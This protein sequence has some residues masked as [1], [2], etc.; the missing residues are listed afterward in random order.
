MK[1]TNESI[2]QAAVLLYERVAQTQPPQVSIEL[3]TYAWNRIQD[4]HRRIDTARTRGWHHA[5]K[6]LNID[7]ATAVEDCRRR[8]LETHDCLQEINGTP[9]Y[10]VS[11][12][13]IHRDLTA[14]ESEFTAL[15]IDLKAHELAVTTDEITLEDV[16][17]GKFE[18]R[19]N[20]DDLGKLRKPYR[21][22][23][24]DPHPAAK[25]NDVTHP[26]VQDE[27]LCEGEGKPAIA[28][29]LSAGR[30]YDFFMLVS[31][32]LHTYGRGAAFVELDEW[33]CVPCDDCGSNVDSDDR[34]LCHRCDATLCGECSCTCPGCDE[35][36][37]SGCLDK[38]CVCEEEF[39]WSCL[40]TCPECK[41]QCCED[42]QKESGLCQRCHNKH[43]KEPEH[44]STEDLE[45]E[46][47]TMAA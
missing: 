31:Q 30:F 43:H 21:V 23:A 4:L 9:C 5:V 26:H 32:V 13:D 29:A 28:A 7:L 17:L 15:A 19:L 46:V 14:L 40:N 27:Q 37:C 25:N 1:R 38:C 42:C 16:F 3:P 45:R 44:D 34:C 36:F 11:V 41:K 35:G 6:Q 18:I 12:A 24:R 22:I 20:W 33:G 8:L 10:Q 2:V 39:C 47:Q